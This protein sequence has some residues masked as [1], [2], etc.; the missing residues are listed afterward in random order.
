MITVRAQFTTE[1]ER[2]GRLKQRIAE[3]EDKIAELQTANEQLAAKTN[4]LK[5]MA[6]P[7]KNFNALI[8]RLEDQLVEN[9]EKSNCMRHSLESSQPSPQQLPPC[10]RAAEPRS[11]GIR[12]WPF[13]GPFLS[14]SPN[15]RVHGIHHRLSY[16]A[17]VMSS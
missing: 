11:G 10:R 14:D 6:V 1:D 7:K 3:L 17:H 8:D 13:A 15:S 12:V 9:S 4:Q 5:E 2:L 16:Y